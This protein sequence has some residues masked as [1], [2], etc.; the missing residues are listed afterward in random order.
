LAADTPGAGAGGRD[1]QGLICC[2]QAAR[3]AFRTAGEDVPRVE[4]LSP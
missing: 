2:Y 1:P 4:G 3:A